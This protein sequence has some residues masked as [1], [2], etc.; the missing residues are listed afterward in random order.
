M[1]KKDWLGWLNTAAVDDA[2]LFL[3][4]VAVCN[5]RNLFFVPEFLWTNSMKAE[6]TKMIY[7]NISSLELIRCIGRTVRTV[8]LLRQKYF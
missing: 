3:A 8:E 7:I 1:E 5:T 2:F 4:E 6:S